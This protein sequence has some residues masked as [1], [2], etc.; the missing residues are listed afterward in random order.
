M[1]CRLWAA[2]V[3]P[4]LLGIAVALDLPPAADRPL[5]PGGPGTTEGLD[6]VWVMHAIAEL[7]KQNAERKAEMQ[8]E[9]E[10]REVERQQ[11]RQDREAERQQER[12]LQGALEAQVQAQNLRV[13]ALAGLR[14]GSMRTQHVSSCESCPPPRL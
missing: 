1:V 10:D 6:S 3:V 7:V 12:E 11:E 4:G 9:R 13:N 2:A 5:A 14:Y 8:K